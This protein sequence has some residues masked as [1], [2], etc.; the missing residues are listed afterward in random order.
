LE[1]IHQLHVFAWRIPEKERKEVK[2]LVDEVKASCA[3]AC[4]SLRAPASASK[5]SK[6]SGAASSSKDGKR[7]EAAQAAFNLSLLLEGRLLRALPMGRQRNYRRVGF[8]RVDLVFPCV[9]A[10]NGCECRRGL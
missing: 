8:V 3:S 5:R 1:D 4:A 9:G 6:T 2:L 7:D 10:N